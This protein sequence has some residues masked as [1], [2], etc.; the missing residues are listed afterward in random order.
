MK[1]KTVKNNVILNNMLLP[2][3]AYIN[4]TYKFEICVKQN[5]GAM[6][7]RREKENT[8]RSYPQT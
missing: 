3:N 1:P 5:L 8:K 2:N 7:V 6:S 4:C